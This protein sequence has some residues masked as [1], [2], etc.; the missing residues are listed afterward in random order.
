MGETHTHEV[1]AVIDGVSHAGRRDDARDLMELMTSVTG[2]EP[3][4]WG[5]GTVGFGEYHY[6]YTTG[7]EGDFFKVGFA[8]RKD[9]I[10]L[11]IMSGLRGFEDILERL[12]SHQAGKSTVHL[13]RLGD[14][15]R[16]ALIELIEE[17][18]A[19]LNAVEAS[20]G[21]IPRM[22][23]IPPRESDG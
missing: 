8:P 7:Q 3:R 5:V 22:S 9:R 17:C 12:G 6:R 10:T 4:V 16:D 11:Y 23:E 2:E 1:Q 14:V 21:A 19:H 18:V 15:D 20:M 13:K